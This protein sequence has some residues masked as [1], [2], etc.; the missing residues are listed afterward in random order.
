MNAIND[1]HDTGGSGPTPS[2]G[3]EHLAQLSSA[4]LRMSTSLD[5]ETVLREAVEGARALTGSEHGLIVTF[6]DSGQLLDLVQLG[7]TQEELDRVIAWGDGPRFFEHLRNID[8]PLGNE[9]LPRY[10]ESLGLSPLPME[11]GTFQLTPMR[12][13]GRPVD[14]FF[15]VAK[16]GTFTK[17]D[18][19]ILLLFASQAAA[20]ID[21][22]RVHKEVQRARGDLETLVE[23]S[24]VGVVV[25]D[26]ASATPLLVNATA[27]R[28]VADLNVPVLDSEKLKTISC[29]RSDGHTVAL[30]ELPRAETLRAEEVE[31][32]APSGRSVRTLLNV[33]PIHSPEGVTQSVVVTMQDL[34]PF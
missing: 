17:A 18:A 7:I 23:T 30:D 24:P 4:V 25:F 29:R 13:R 12:H 3:Q 9:T 22:A 32:S 1:T 26:V 20:A 10:V 16:Q 6:D 33:T 11:F 5:I 15:M 21:N 31:L 8:E 2:S 28:I 19:E 27:R 14:G 34:A